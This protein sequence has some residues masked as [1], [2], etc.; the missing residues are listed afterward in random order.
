[1]CIRH[2]HISPGNPTTDIPI[3]EYLVNHMDISTEYS[4]PNRKEVGQLRRSAGQM[5]ASEDW[6]YH[7]ITWDEAVSEVPLSPGLLKVR[8]QD[9]FDYP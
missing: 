3:F 6:L 2:N 9:F 4:L 5:P 8:F 7:S 1:M